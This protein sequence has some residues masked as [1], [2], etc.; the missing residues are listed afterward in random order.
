ML[1][2]IKTLLHLLLYRIADYVWNYILDSLTPSGEASMLSHCS[3][4]NMKSQKNK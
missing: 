4:F 2:Q 1:M 3:C